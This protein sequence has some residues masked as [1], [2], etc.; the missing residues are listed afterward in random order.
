MDG[1]GDTQP[2]MKS[3][4]KAEMKI[5]CIHNPRSVGNPNFIL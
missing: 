2:V 1:G 4:V 5:R 3:S